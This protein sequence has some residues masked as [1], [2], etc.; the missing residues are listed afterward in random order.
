MTPYEEAHEYYQ[1][2]KWSTSSHLAEVFKQAALELITRRLTRPAR[3]RKY[4][5]RRKV[6]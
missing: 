6:A 5:S 1:L 3:K 4:R 2:L